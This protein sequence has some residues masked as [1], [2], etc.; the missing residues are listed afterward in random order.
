MFALLL[1]GPFYVAV[2]F[3]W[4]DW[5]KNV[6]LVAQPQGWSRRLSFVWILLSDLLSISC[7]FS[8]FPA[9]L[10]LSRT[11]T[12]VLGVPFDAF[13][14]ALL[15]PAEC[16]SVLCT[17]N[18]TSCDSVCTMCVPVS[19]NCVLH[20][21]KQS[22]AGCCSSRTVAAGFQC[23]TLSLLRCLSGC[24]HKLLWHTHTQKNYCDTHI[25]KKIT[26]THTY[27]QSVICSEQGRLLP[28]CRPLTISWF[29]LSN[30]HLNA[31]K[32]TWGR[33]W[34]RESTKICQDTSEGWTRTLPGE[35]SF[36]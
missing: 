10:S 28:Q 19:S 29:S 9:S 2:I 31:V 36:H 24:V 35:R 25:L 21:G 16:A 12:V 32:S 30:L 14:F 6:T 8:F 27:T 5:L 1:P 11:V 33:M 13:S 7:P 3:S 18:A 22:D 20:V 23:H 4:H 26:V 15:S 17:F 34:V